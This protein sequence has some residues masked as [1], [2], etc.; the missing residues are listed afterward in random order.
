MPKHVEFQQIIA[1]SISYD[2]FEIPRIR[3][4]DRWRVIKNADLVQNPHAIN[5]YDR[6][7][8]ALH[9]TEKIMQ[10]LSERET[11]VCIH[12]PAIV[13]IIRLTD[14]GAAVQA[15][16]GFILFHLRLLSLQVRRARHA[17]AG[18]GQL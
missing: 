8:D 10:Q 6:Y 12:L 4:G 14:I 5:G 11:S 9:R 3:D 7:E 17:S 2:R 13:T 18:C 15:M 16:C 1:R